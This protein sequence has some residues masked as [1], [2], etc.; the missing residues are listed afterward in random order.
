MLPGEFQ[1]WLCGGKRTEETFAAAFH[2][3]IGDASPDFFEFFPVIG[4]E[5]VEGI[6][7]E[8]L[9]AGFA[10]ELDGPLGMG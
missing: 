5:R 1:M 10:D 2:F 6:D 4:V 3:L 8:F 9:E 7:E